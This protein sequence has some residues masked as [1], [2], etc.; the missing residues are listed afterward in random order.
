MAGLPW[1]IVYFGIAAYTI[2]RSTVAMFFLLSIIA[3]VAKVLYSV[4]LYPKFFTPLKHIPTP[5]RRSWLTGNTSSYYIETPYEEMRDWIVSVPNNGLIRY[6]MTGNLER[7]LLTSPKSLGEL[8]VH[9]VYEF[10]KPE[11]IRASLSRVTGLNGLLLVEGEEHKRQRKNLMPAFSYRHIKDLYPIFWEKSIEMVRCIEDDLQKRAD[12]TTTIGTWASRTTLDIIG[13]AGM[14]HDF[15]T[16][17]DPENDLHR[18]YQKLLSEPPPF[19]KL[20]YVLAMCIGKPDLVNQ[21]P[22]RRNREIKEGSEIIRNVA[23][24]M[25]RKKQEKL[26]NTDD[27]SSASSEVDIISVALKSGSFTEDELIDQMMTF[28]G[29][30]HETTSTAL[31]WAA[32]A[33]CKHPE[34]QTRLREEVRTHLPSI[35]TT[36]QDRQ[37]ISAAAIDALPYLSAVCN[38][39][40]RFHPSIPTTVRIAGRDTTLVGTTIP[41]GTLFLIVANVINHSKELWGADADVF[42]PDRWLGPGRAN[43]GGASSNYAFLSFLHG[44]R[45]CIGQGFSKAELACL[46]AVLV[47]RFQMELVNPDAKLEVRLSATICPKDGVPVRLTALEGW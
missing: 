31:Q 46:I 36:D 34:V 22:F 38:E 13:V 1:P 5:P 32:Y 21:L 16:L 28:L 37:P 27:S 25:I 8:L 9:K 6:Y 4:A 30:G 42:N 17:R 43:T 20:I 10:P 33:L 24:Q 47:G 29:A 41:K 15:S 14:D 35:S 44:P 26:D 19:M 45:G 40:L 12:Y 39:V 23:R 3:T 7:I 18:S 11:I 2:T